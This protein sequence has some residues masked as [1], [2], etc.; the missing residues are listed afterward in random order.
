[1]GPHVRLY[2]TLTATGIGPEVAGDEDQCLSTTKV[3]AEMG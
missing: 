1:M 2:C 3:Q